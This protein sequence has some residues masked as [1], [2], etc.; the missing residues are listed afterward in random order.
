MN[1]VSINIFVSIIFV[2]IYI[3]FWIYTQAL[4][5]WAKGSVQG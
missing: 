1:K 4:D 3:I 2:N 5:W